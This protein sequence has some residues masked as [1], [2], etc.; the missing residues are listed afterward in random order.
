M[1]RSTGLALL[2]V[3]FAGLAFAGGAELYGQNCA[4]CHGP[5]GAGVPGAFPPLRGNPHAADPGYVAKVIREGRSGP[6]TVGGQTYNGQ[7]PPFGQLSDADVRALAE[8]V[9]TELAGAK[10]EAPK[11]RAAAPAGDPEAGKALFLGR[12]RF[13]NGGP[14]C[15]ACHNAKAVGALG[16]GALGPDLSDAGQKFGASLPS[17]IERPGFR[18][19]RAVYKNKPLTPEEARDVAAFLS[20]GEGSGV[21]LASAGGRY[22]FLGALGLAV[23][24]LILL[25]FWPRQRLTYRDR[26]RRKP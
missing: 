20:Q 21:A 12:R 26:L 19:M 10:A 3:F 7:M 1:R 25:P 14:P 23:L 16:G 24:V 18:V 6:L 9:A 13:K 22:F 5:T 8:Y 4:A 2:L 11:A 15:V 17:L